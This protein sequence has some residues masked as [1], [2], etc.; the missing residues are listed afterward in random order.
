MRTAL[1]MDTGATNASDA[2]VPSDS[3]DHFFEGW[4]MGFWAYYLKDSATNGWSSSM[5]GADGR[6]LADGAWDG[7]S[8]AAGFASSEPGDPVPAVAN[9]FAVELVAAQGLFGAS[10]YDDAASVLG[11]PSTN[12][13]DSWGSMSGGTTE[14]RVKLVEPAYNLDSTQ[15]RK[16][17]T[18]LQEGS[19]LV[20]R[21]EQPIKDDPSHPYGIDLLVFGNAF[22]TSSG[23]VN[24]S[25]DMNTLML[26]GGGFFEPMK[27]SVSPGY[28][29]KSGQNPTNSATWDW[30]R[31]DNG[32][33][34]DTAFPT[35]AYHWNRTNST[36]SNELMDFTKPVNPAFGPVLE[37]GDTAGLSAAD[38]IDLYDGS[39]G[40]TGFDLADSGFTSIQYVKVEG[41]T[42]FS[43][44]EI[45]AISM[46][47]P[48]VVGDSLTIA[49]DNLTNGT[50][51]LRFQR[52][53]K[54]AQP[55][56]TVGFANLSDVARVSTALLPDPS[57]LAP[58]GRVLNGAGLKLLPIFGSNT[59]TFQ[60]NLRLM[61]G[62]DYAGNG[63][64]L[65]LL[66]Q[67]GSDWEDVA[68]AFEA[69]TWSVLVSGV[70]NLPT[71]ALLQAVPPQITMTLGVDGFGDPLTQV[72]FAALPGFIYS[73]ERTTDF[74]RWEEKATV[75]PLALGMASLNYGD[76][77]SSAF[78]RVR[79]HRP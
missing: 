48:M 38:A 46:A 32:P 4:N 61:T 30:Y 39:G 10:P 79:V 23:F 5:T 43:G 27:V 66:R 11:M 22:Y 63:D 72:H 37:S 70:T 44:G 74:V 14:R 57:A 26:A 51:T 21:F 2:R 71:L 53:W 13:F 62:P 76:S 50:A 55:A 34:A 68:F 75:M 58:Y 33:Y 15:T 73:L 8:F 47:R 65:V 69:S 60:A 25:T 31:Y 54:L 78:Y 45:D 7:F 56:I 77:A 49:P 35:H 18:S 12:F 20:V 9:P 41:L 1:V 36:W 29:G 42:G 16:L 64:D 3:T 52:P 59:V 6:I 24:D 40:G 17:I 28:T 67:V 19:S